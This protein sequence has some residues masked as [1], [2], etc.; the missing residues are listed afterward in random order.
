MEQEQTAW[1]SRMKSRMQGVEAMLDQVFLAAS[2]GLGGDTPFIWP[3]AGE[4]CKGVSPYSWY[5][6]APHPKLFKP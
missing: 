6:G 4:N 3:L 1:A 2:Y 5:K